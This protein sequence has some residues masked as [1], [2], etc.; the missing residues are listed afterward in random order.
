MPIVLVFPKANK[1]LL[2][3]ELSDSMALALGV[4]F[5]KYDEKTGKRTPVADLTGTEAHLRS[6]SYYIEMPDL[7]EDEGSPVVQVELTPRLDRDEEIQEL[8]DELVAQDPSLDEP[9]NQNA[10]DVLL[11]FG[12]HLAELEG[13]DA[14]AF[15]IAAHAECGLLVPGAGEEEETIW[16][17]SADDFAELAFP[18]EN[19]IGG[20]ELP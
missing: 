18:D 1:P 6:G 9:M 4:P 19:E 16:C 12:D 15:V 14:L 10:V 5:S 8:I 7:E 3:P 11:T 17:D 20:A 13:G 2:L